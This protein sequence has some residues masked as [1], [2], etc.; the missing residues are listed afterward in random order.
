MTTQLA[1]D[2]AAD[3]LYG[4]DVDELKIRWSNYDGSESAVIS[5]PGSPI[6]AHDGGITVDHASGFLFWSDTLSD[7]IFRANLDGSSATAIITSGLGNPGSLVVVR[8]PE[9]S[10]GC[11]FLSLLATGALMPRRRRRA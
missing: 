10:V 2:P 3:K 5:S 8:N 9:P 7:R 4:T 11:V 1:V 6:A